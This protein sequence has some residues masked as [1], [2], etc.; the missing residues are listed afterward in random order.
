MLDV[1]L[2]ELYNTM[3][4]IVVIVLSSAE[5]ISERGQQN[6]QQIDSLQ[7]SSVHQ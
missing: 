5:A 2:R 3:Y 6:T 7:L 4:M 1:L